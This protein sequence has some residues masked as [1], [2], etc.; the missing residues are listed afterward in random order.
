NIDRLRGATSG[1]RC[2]RRGARIERILDRSSAPSAGTTASAAF[3]RKPG[4]LGIENALTVLPRPGLL[5]ERSGLLIE[6]NAAGAANERSIEL[7]DIS[8]VRQGPW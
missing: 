5:L 1:R 8:G 4:G 2:L 7:I 6:R 3:R